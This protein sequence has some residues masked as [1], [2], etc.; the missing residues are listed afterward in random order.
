MNS[1]NHNSTSSVP[2]VS[3]TGDRNILYF[4]PNDLELCLQ[5]ASS[6]CADDLFPR[7]G[8]EHLKRAPINL[9]ELNLTDKQLIAVS[10]VFYGGARKQRAAKAMKISSQAVSEHLTAALKKIGACFA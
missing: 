8:Y 5:T 7:P 9:N 3:E 4:A 6:G 2:E 10:L 1:H